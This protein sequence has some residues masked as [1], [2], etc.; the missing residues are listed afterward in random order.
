MNRA[1]RYNA[2]PS[3]ELSSVDIRDLDLG[4][5][6]GWVEDLLQQYRKNP[7]SVDRSWYPLFAELSGVP[8]PTVAK[9]GN[10]KLAFAA[11][12]QPAAS[13]LQERAA[14]LIEAYR[15]RGH[16]K[17]QLDPLGLEKRDAPELR[18]EA[19]GL[20]DND[21]ETAFATG[22][23]AG[24]PIAT[25]REIVAHLEETYCRSIG[26]E[27]MQGEEPARRLWLQERMES[28]ENHLR[29][30]RQEQ[31][32][33]LEKLTE[34]E[35]LET[36]L[37]TKY[38]GAKRFS[39]EGAESLIPLLDLLIDAAAQHGADEVVI[40]MAH[41]G[42][43]NTIAHI[44]EKPV[45]E[46]FSEFEDKD[47][48]AFMGR[49]DVKYHMGHSADVTTA[50]G[51]KMHLSLAFNPSHLEWVNTVVEGRVRAKQDRLGDRA[52]R[53]AVPLLVHGDA[54]FAGQGI[55]AE[56]LN[57]SELAGYRVGGTLHVVLNNQV[58]F[59]TNP[60]DGRSTPYCTDI[61]RMLRVPVFHVNGEDPEA[62][63]WVAKLAAEYRF[64]FGQDVLIDL[65]C[66]RKHGH[67]ETDEPA[68][69]QPVMVRAIAAKKSVRASYVEKL[70]VT[71][72][73]TAADADAIVKKRYAALDTA[74]E[75]T[76]KN[77]QK[78]QQPSAMAGLW[79]RYKG[80]AKAG[81]PETPTAV[82]RALL[83]DQITR[84]TTV[85]DGFTPHPKIAQLLALRRQMGEGSKPLDWSTAE[86]AAF[87]SLLWEGTPIRFSGQDSGRGTFSQ[88]HAVLSDFN[89][90]QHFTPL[91]HLKKDQ[92]RFE[93]Y[94]SP[95]SEAGVLGFEYGYS[96]DYPD[97]LVLWE[98]QFGDF[99]NAAQVIIDQF[100][101]AAEDKWM[102][103]SGLVLLLPHGF[104]GQGPE[105]SSARLERFLSLAAEDNIQ[106][107]NL[108][109]PAQYFHVLRRQVV[110]PW[111]KPLV[112]M[113]PKSLLRHKAAV[114]DLDELATGHFQRVIADA[115]LPAAKASR[116]ILCTGKVYYDLIQSRSD[117]KRDDVAIVRV[118][119]L[120]PFPADALVAVANAPKGVPVVW[121][122]EEPWN[123]GAQYFLRPRLEKTLGR[124]VQYVCR[125]ESASP[126]TGSAASHKVEQQLL[127]DQAFGE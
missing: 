65:Y 105:H 124:P 41:R 96:L 10:G 123:M 108:T 119:E 78:R 48:A 67:N 120:Y 28:V 33:I 21:L 19:F 8:A 97:G 40:G 15:E 122:Q 37:H 17:A 99:V 72:Q 18:L 34:A 53:R 107:C 36:F 9:N 5:N 44:L 52:G 85:M 74:L 30:T 93:L 111:R 24:P 32:R 87:A 42:R 4:V 14:E 61:A 109:T 94:D 117:K 75:T 60:S 3:K 47:A 16:L 127:M 63:A 29:L 58:G 23:L 100:L 55:I 59:T 112:L 69:T 45:R 57:L 71:G 82:P 2:A 83:T 98:A 73:V 79:Q 86:A 43:L 27:F 126:A 6:T 13:D 110:R 12:T 89:T 70:T 91:S 62:V 92:G 7:S 56:M 80:G 113:T 88:R 39:L 101:A 84:M 106:V 95:L 115:T 38:L 121:V 66:Y 31:M 77:N 1:S 90:G 104:E 51:K 50:S 26:V 35:V 46:I 114:S 103:L 125:E 81:I 20:R 25:L 68:F 54:A 11:I 49:G 102:R 64:Q 118:E 116:V 22:D 76:R